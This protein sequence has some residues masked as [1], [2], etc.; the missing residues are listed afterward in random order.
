MGSSRFTNLGDKGLILQKQDKSTIMQLSV[1]TSE[2]TS[3]HNSTGY[4]SI[5]TGKSSDNVAQQC[6]ESRLSI[7]NT[8][9]VKNLPFLVLPNTSKSHFPFERTNG[10]VSYPILSHT[11]LK[12]LKDN[13]FCSS[14]SCSSS[15]HKQCS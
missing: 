11:N 14:R 3:S 9:V 8:W 2:N 5:S 6:L 4:P 1:F 13:L 7:R 10:M 12:S 15:L